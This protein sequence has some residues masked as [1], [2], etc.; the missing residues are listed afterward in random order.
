MAVGTIKV[1]LLNAQP[2]VRTETPVAE[3]VS[4]PVPPPPPRTFTKG[5][6]EVNIAIAAP[7]LTEAEDFLCGAY[8]GLVDAASGTSLSVYTQEFSTITRFAEIKSDLEDASRKPTGTEIKRSRDEVITDLS[9]CSVTVGQSGSKAMN[10]DINFTCIKPGALELSA[11]AVLVILS[12]ADPG[13]SEIKD[14]AERAAGNS[15]VYWIIT[16][17]DETER[18]WGGVNADPPKASVKKQLREKIGV[19]CR[20]GDHVAFAQ[21]YGGIKIASRNGD[22]PTFVSHN[23]SRD[24]VPCGCHI[25]LIDAIIS[26]LKLKAGGGDAEILSAY[27]MVKNGFVKVEPIIGGWCEYYP[28]DE[29]GKTE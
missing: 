18:L 19:P 6:A 16:G 24:Y 21:T 25:P 29:G 23:V 26:A 12:A 9:R 27:N 1:K 2:A 22:I 17:F 14:A 15:P 28:G 8:F 11:D 4:A 20:S 3:P 7:T 5:K 10:I 13:V